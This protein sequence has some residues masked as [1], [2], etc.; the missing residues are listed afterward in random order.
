MV[1]VEE[2]LAKL[3][4]NQD[5]LFHY[6]DEMRKEIKDMKSLVTA[7]EKIAVKVEGIDTKVSA[8]D[9]RM[10]DVE[11]LPAKKFDKYKEIIFSTLISLLLGG[12]VG[13]LLML[14]IK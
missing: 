12:I 5:T 9:K 11:K 14:I 8:I 1:T 13:A 3:E 4:T 2:R 10:T 7:V 6:I